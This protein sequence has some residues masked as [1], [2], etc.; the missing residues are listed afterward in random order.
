MP[1]TL[2]WDKF[3]EGT[4]SPRWLR[5]FFQMHLILAT[6]VVVITYLLV[7]FDFIV[8]DGCYRGDP[9]CLYLTITISLLTI[10]AIA[11][12][13]HVRRQK[14]PPTLIF[15]KLA[16]FYLNYIISAVTLVLVPGTAALFV[17]WYLIMALYSVLYPLY[18]ITTIFAWIVILIVEHIVEKTI[19]RYI[20]NA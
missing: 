9:A 4:I 15:A 10:A 19:T 5:R 11:A 13:V 12:M 14:Q 3:E 1:L 6:V 18:F 7:G 2:I 17:C 16:P 8:T 20:T